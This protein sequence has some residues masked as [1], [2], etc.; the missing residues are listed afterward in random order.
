MDCGHNRLCL[1]KKIKRL[2]VFLIFL[3]VGI[4]FFPNIEI[5]AQR[6]QRETLL[7]RDR[8]HVKNASPAASPQRPQ[9]APTP[10]TSQPGT[11]GTPTYSDLYSE[12]PHPNDPAV[13][14]VAPVRTDNRSSAA[15]S[16]TQPVPRENPSRW[17]GLQVVPGNRQAA[18]SATT[19]GRGAAQGVGVPSRESEPWQVQMNLEGV[20]GMKTEETVSLRDVPFALG[21]GRVDL[22]PELMTPDGR[23]IPLQLREIHEPPLKEIPTRR[24]VPRELSPM[25]SD[26]NIKHSLWDPDETMNDHG[27]KVV[28]WPA[29]AADA[30]D[31]DVK[32][33]YVNQAAY[34]QT[35]VDV[36]TRVPTA[37][38]LTAIP[39]QPQETHAQR[40]I[41][42]RVSS[43][44]MPEVGLITPPENVPL[45]KV[46]PVVTVASAANP[47]GKVFSE[48]PQRHELVVPDSPWY[49]E[50]IGGLCYDEHRFLSEC[51]AKAK[52]SYSLMEA[53][54]IASHPSN[55]AMANRLS[56][57]Y[58]QAEA[59]LLSRITPGDSKLRR[60]EKILV[61]MHEELMLGGYQLEQTTME[62]LFSNGRYNCVT[63]TILYCCLGRAAGL[64]VRAVELPGHAMCWVKTE[65][66]EIDVETTCAT[67][68]QY[69]DDAATRKRVIRDLIRQAQDDVDTAQVRAISDREL[70]A[71]V[72]YN[73]GVDFLAVKDFRAALESNAIALLLDP[74]SSTTKGNLLATINNWAL[75]LCYEG[76]FT[77][78]AEL[79]RKGLLEEPEYAMFR[80]NHVHVYHC[81]IDNLYRGGQMQEA[82]SVAQT[83]LLE[84]P[85]EPHFI[86]L[87]QQLE[88]R[89]QVMA[90][91]PSWIR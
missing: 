24:D 14:D 61:F 19:A 33:L 75:N 42:P 90:G 40:E 28:S 27:I 4:C 82:L 54:I 11:T 9:Y 45:A 79:L 51:L 13:R 26:G 63:A 55:P 66:G 17:G 2:I 46:G 15:A 49:V 65:R 89:A 34:S 69:L 64:E 50:Y 72:Y 91:N 30:D 23:T 16:P 62:N 58:K 52:T 6:L 36:E 70:I 68:F 10:R 8:D 21:D 25:N 57:S 31:E 38:K 22:G 39:P 53:S 3:L 5:F 76:K 73:R 48:I 86:K 74:T 77:Q 83:A 35:D 44:V 12:Y 80:K 41:S 59:K 78:S 56:R 18:P 71:K 81:W 84:Q 87:S 47:P 60:A 43:P 88:E 37:P 29:D 32:T 1:Y 7:R 67:W 85:T 20:P